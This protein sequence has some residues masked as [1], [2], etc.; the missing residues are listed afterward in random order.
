MEEDG[1]TT[2]GHDTGTATSSRAAAG[3]SASRPAAQSTTSSSSSSSSSS[4]R[5]TGQLE[6]SVPVIL[7]MERLLTSTAPIPADTPTPSPDELDALFDS[8]LEANRMND[9]ERCFA[10]GL[11]GIDR[12]DLRQRLYLFWKPFALSLPCH[13]EA[14]G[15]VAR[16]DLN[17]KRGVAV[18]WLPE[19]K[20][21]RVEFP[22]SSNGSARTC[23]QVAIRPVNL[24]AASDNALLVDQ[25]TEGRCWNGHSWQVSALRCDGRIPVHGGVCCIVEGPYLN[26][27]DEER[28]DLERGLGQKDRKASA[29]VF[30]T[31]GYAHTLKSADLGGS[32]LVESAKIKMNPT[33][34][35]NNAFWVDGGKGLLV[36]TIDVESYTSQLRML[37]YPDMRLV[38]AWD[39]S[40]GEEFREDIWKADFYENC[41]AILF[42]T[43]SAAGSPSTDTRLCCYTYHKGRLTRDAS[44]EFTGRLAELQ[45]QHKRINDLCVTCGGVGGAVATLSHNGI[46]RLW[47]T[48]SIA[49][50]T[51]I[52]NGSLENLGRPGTVGGL[53]EYD[54]GEGKIVR[55]PRVMQ[56][57]LCQHHDLDTDILDVA[58]CHG[59]SV[60][61]FQTSQ[62]RHRFPARAL[63]MSNPIVADTT[64]KNFAIDNGLSNGVCIQVA[65]ECTIYDDDDDGEVQDVVQLAVWSPFRK[66]AILAYELPEALVMSAETGVRFVGGRL[67]IAGGVSDA[68]R[69]ARRGEELT[70]GEETCFIYV[71]SAREDEGFKGN[72][73]CPDLGIVSTGVRGM[74]NDLCSRPNSEKPQGVNLDVALPHAC[75]GDGV[76]PVITREVRPCC[77]LCHGCGNFECLNSMSNCSGC[78]S[79][80]YCSR[81]CQKRAWPVHKPFCKA[82]QAV[83]QFLAEQGY[84]H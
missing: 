21:F 81:T 35:V 64:V 49:G 30:T 4:S 61:F 24:R 32:M 8:L 79:A 34:F 47:R 62:T 18:S 68:R 59:G 36:T 54:S 55:V 57:E 15:L 38:K 80:M 82:T 44:W 45:Y 1:E 28:D 73:R 22:V 67:L 70:Y 11:M 33:L 56:K 13:V 60:S 27:T 65:E 51:A 74:L 48:D 46:V 23:K 66:A 72:V 16:S 77:S 19:Q 71:V 43:R 50:C 83:T 84:G 41:L 39:A 6:T 26:Q 20:R 75:P 29:V 25:P 17:G 58:V 2:A 9:P 3:P 10:R 5:P 37:S 40:D 7:E 14:R 63:A 53:D 69:S 31:H 78:G 76:P 42:S 12:A 52:L